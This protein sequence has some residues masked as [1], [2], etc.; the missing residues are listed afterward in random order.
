[1]KEK[2]HDTEKNRKTVKIDKK[3]HF[4][5]KLRG[6]TGGH[7]TLPIRR[8]WMLAKVVKEEKQIDF[9][10]TGRFVGKNCELTAIHEF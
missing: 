1:M 8:F 6:T 9:S 3:N 2:T 4:L 7:P 5:T 10:P